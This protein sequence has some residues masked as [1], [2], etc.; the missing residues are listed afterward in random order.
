M[1][2]K[3]DKGY[4]MFVLSAAKKLDSKKAKAILKSK[5][6]RFA[7]EDELMEITSCKPGAIPPFGNLFGLQMFVDESLLSQD[8]INF[9]AGRNDTSI[10]MK[11]KDYLEIVEPIIDDFSN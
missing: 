9:N 2:V 7:T 1:I 3:A 5:N 11:L 10:E 4:Y 8:I 6:L